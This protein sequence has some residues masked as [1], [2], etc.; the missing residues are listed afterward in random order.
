VIGKVAVMGWRHRENGSQIRMEVISNRKKHQVESHRRA[1]EVGSN[2]ST[3]ALC[4]YGR[5]AARGYVH[6]VIVT[7]HAEACRVLSDS[8]W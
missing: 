6:G 3:D 2:I 8:A 4:S 5:M 1:V 7:D